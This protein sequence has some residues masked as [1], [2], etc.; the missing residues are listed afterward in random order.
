MDE[1][2]PISSVAFP[3][4]GEA[5]KTGSWR[6]LCPILHEEKCL[7]VKTGKLTCLRCWLYCPEACIIRKIPPQIDY[8]YCKGCS[9]CAEVCPVDAIEIVEESKFQEMQKNG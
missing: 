1:E 4:E 2:R 7:T 6:T 9:V 5:G 8:D 3:T